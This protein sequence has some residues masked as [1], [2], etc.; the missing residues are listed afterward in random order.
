MSYINCRLNVLDNF[1]LISSD[2][3][4]LTRM[5]K[6]AKIPLLKNYAIVPL[7]LSPDVDQEL[8]VGI[9]LQ[10]VTLPTTGIC[11]LGF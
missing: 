9:L 1:A 7:L 4:S 3:N 6:N 2:I 8:Q 5:I 11:Q 10:M